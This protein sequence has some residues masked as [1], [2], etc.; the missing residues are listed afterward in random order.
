MQNGIPTKTSSVPDSNWRVAHGT[1]FVL[2]VI[3]GLFFPALRRWP[4]VWLVPFAIYFLAAAS[5]PQLRR[6]LHWLSAGRLSVATVGTTLAAMVVTALALLT[7]HATARPDVDGFRE[8]HS[9]N[10]IGGV[11]VGGVIFTIV[12]ATLEE[13][14]FRG[15]LFD[16]L[17]SQWGPWITL[18]V[19][20]ALFG[21][22]HWSGYPPG[23]VGVCLATLF[24]FAMGALRLWTRG[25]A[26][27]IA[28]HMVADATIYFLVLRS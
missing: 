19:T 12:N 5:I 23:P 10:A 14:A 22:G 8:L 9:L 1:V 18:I 20:S 6:S 26:L 7:F 3:C 16:A 11:V 15:I 2:L 24:G 28:A 27:P 17:D 25:L 4:W 13:L 21:L